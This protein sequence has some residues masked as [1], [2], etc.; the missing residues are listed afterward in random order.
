V[1]VDAFSNT[2]TYNGTSWLI[3]RDINGSK[4]LNSVSCPS[5]S[6]CVAVDS[7]GNALIATPAAY[8][9]NG[10]FVGSAYEHLLS[11]TPDSGGLTYWENQLS[12]GLSRNAVAGAIL[13]ST[14][15]GSDLVNGYYETFLGRASET[16]GLMY[17]VAQLNTGAK[18]ESVLAAIVGSSEFYAGSGGTS[19]GFVT[20]LYTKLLG[21]AP[22]SAGLTYWEN[23]LS[24]GLSRNAVAGALL[25]ST[26][27]R[28][29]LVKGYYETFLGRAPDSAGLAY[30]VGQLKAGA[31]DESVLAAILGSAEFYTDATT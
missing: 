30:W 16:T 4:A 21:R 12:K 31:K 29:D 9:R 5:A 23:Q 13:A 8:T 1:A 18:E 11:R 2:L 14:E 20:A 22:E 10:A 15:Y 3:T 27:Y 17:W 7:Y 28:T 25:G 24:K 6:F 19:A 26:E